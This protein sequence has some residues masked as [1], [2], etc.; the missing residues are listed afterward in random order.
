[1]TE[2]SGQITIKDVSHVMKLLVGSLY[3]HDPHLA[4]RELIQNAHDALVD[5][6]NSVS[7]RD[8]SVTLRLWAMDA[9]P[10]LEIQDTGI[11]L[12]GTEMKENFGKIGD[13]EKLQRA[14]EKPEIIGRFGIGFLSAFI[15]ADH[16]EVLTKKHDALAAGEDGGYWLWATRDQQN[17]TLA[18][19]TPQKAAEWARTGDFRHGTRV[20]LYFRDRY[21]GTNAERINDLR[22]IDGI[23]KIVRA[24]CYL[25]PFAIRVAVR[26][27]PG[28]VANLVRAPWQSD[29]LAAEAFKALFGK[30]A[31][32]FTHRFER[33][34]PNGRY[35]VAGVLYFRE[36]LNRTPSVQL[37][38]KRMLV[39]PEDRQLIPPYGVFASGIVDCPQ[40]EVDLSRRQV[41]PFDPAYKWLRSSMLEEFERAFLE[42]T[43][44]RIE[45]FVSVWPAIDNSFIVHLMDA[46]QNENDDTL[47]AAAKRFLKSGGVKLP[48]YLVDLI[49]GSQG[50][51]T[52]TTIEEFAEKRRR[53]L[54]PEQVRNRSASTD[55]PVDEH[56]RMRVYFTRS[57]QPV[58]KDLLIERYKELFDVGRTEKSHELVFAALQSMGADVPN[59]AL[60]E[61]QASRFGDVD[62]HEAE[63]WTQVR[64]HLQRGLIFSGRSHEVV[65][66][67]F[68]P[69]TIPI[70]ITDTKVDNEQVRTLRDQLSGLN[71]VAGVGQQLIG[72]LEQL[73]SKGGN[74]VIH[75]NARNDLM[76]RL[77]EALAEGQSEL[78]NAATDGLSLIS[79]RAVIDYFGW[80][81]TRDMIGRD[82]ENAHA[83][84][85]NLLT[86]SGETARIRVDLELT[87]SEK[88][89]AER[90]RE[91]AERAL[92]EIV[93]SESAPQKL[94]A[95]CGFVDFVNS[96]QSFMSNPKVSPEERWDV[97]RL[98]TEELQ[99]QIGAFGGTTISFTGDGVLFA[100]LQG[101]KVAVDVRARLANL[102]G[103]LEVAG[104][105]HE[106][107]RALFNRMQE[108]PP[109]LRV[110]LSYGEIYFGQVGPTRNAIGLPIVEAARIA[111]DKALFE[112]SPHQVLSA[113]SAI[114]SG[115]RW[116]L[117]D[118]TDFEKAG[119]VTGKGLNRELEVWRPR[120]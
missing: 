54:T 12:S 85:R 24:N 62:G 101:R 90:A 94:D 10:F 100:V 43:N 39:N 15:V 38:V 55:E 19:L 68:E 66:E 111:G 18:Q 89:A 9:R 53:E 51:P 8:K 75:V 95:I 59:V 87:R 70:I 50:R 69:K 41:A 27:E 16:V 107:L 113:T 56:G 118:A 23:E 92:A 11:G 37:Y 48:F 22:T 82:R 77:R 20:R 84:I 119:V 25:L 79:W 109:R 83:I 112:S 52:W 78:R 44:R 88:D 30:N 80:T 120:F 110:G 4:I 72:F 13:S 42:M 31:P 3:G 86:A 71:N 67:A 61:V 106:V 116:G 28:R 21:D 35:R 76:N 14:L 32:F 47:K 5:L 97:F 29:D 115:A 49:S 93:K 96:T 7:D 117:W 91:A 1:M 2:Q 33:Q 60:V 17:W 74:L 104:T 103:A 6:G 63:R 65:V 64:Q 34:D 45:E 99:R 105:S 73:E 58:E 57:Q 46:Y 26:D 114:N 108:K 81:S 40:L 102:A 98:L 36:Q